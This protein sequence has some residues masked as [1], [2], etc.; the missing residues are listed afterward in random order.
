MLNNRFRTLIKLHWNYTLIRTSTLKKTI[1]WCLIG[2]KY[3]L[4]LVGIGNGF[5]C[6]C[7]NTFKCPTCDGSSSSSMSDCPCMT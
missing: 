7:A 4:Y 1:E 3:S 2:Y 5:N 6:A